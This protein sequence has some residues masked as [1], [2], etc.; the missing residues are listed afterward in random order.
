[1]IFINS[2]RFSP[3]GTGVD[4]PH[5]DDYFHKPPQFI[6]EEF[7]QKGDYYI[8]ESWWMRQHDRCLNGFE[9][10]NAV[11]KGGDMLIDGEDALWTGKDVYLPTYDLVIKNGKVWIS[12]RLYFYL[13][14]WKIYGKLPGRK[15]KGMIYPRFLMLDFFF[16]H[17]LIM[18][19]SQNKDTQDL[20]AR[21]LGFSEKSGGGIL[22]YNY[23]FIK[24]SVNVVV[25]GAQ[26]DSDKTFGNAIRGLGD[27]RNTQFYKETALKRVSPGYIQAK[28]FFSEIHALT[29]KDKPQT[30]S[31]L[32]PTWVVYE[33]I[34]KGKKDWS[35]EVARYVNPSLY[36]EGEKTGWQNRIG[37]GGEM[38][39]GGADLEE[40]H[41][42]PDNHHVLSFPNIFEKEKLPNSDG[43]V[44]HF[45]GKQWF[46]IIDKDGNPE[47]ERSLKAIEIEIANTPVA[48]RHIQ[49]SQW[50]TTAS[51][52]LMRSSIGFFGQEVI[53]MLQ[54]RKVYIISH[55]EE[56]IV[57]RGRLVPKNAQKPFEGVKFIPDP[58]HGWIDIIEE[59]ELDK[60]G[61][62]YSNLYKGGTDSYDQDEAA[63]SSSKGSFTVRK[64]YR[65]GSVSPHYITYVAQIVERPTVAEGGAETF[66]WHTVLGCIYFGCR[67]NIE[68][69]N[70]RIFD[71]YINNGYEVLL[72]ERPRLA[73]AGMIRNSQVSNRYGTDKSLKPHI[74]SILKERLTDD[75]IQRMYFTVQID[76]LAK[77]QYDPSGK[78]YNC[79][80]TIS[81]AEAEVSAKEIEYYV[82]KSREDSKKLTKGYMGFKIKGGVIV[83]TM[84]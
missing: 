80:I 33:E 29:A 62:P 56:Q 49:R 41:Y 82:I 27:L 35:L 20:K 13:N 8:D 55:R 15:I 40:V 42:N 2:H 70:L 68:Y 57:R 28:N 66:F 52:A 50:A 61:K 9:V 11:A 21:Q 67:N 1:M 53:E 77:F 63:T 17:R 23:T 51:D 24:S 5:E 79:D 22:G 30:V 6:T 76:A 47:K 64:M 37:T 4:M 81:T 54:R 71:Y 36:A 65:Q 83:Q 25:G 75:F 84:N 12:G 14:F 59:P 48:K 10:S 72:E 78:K 46:H 38:E 69:S 43:R 58:E 7:L 16:F 19:F 32:T 45:T 73:F 74:L 34:G 26:E 39:E 3:V 31:R 44:A 18:M 60:D